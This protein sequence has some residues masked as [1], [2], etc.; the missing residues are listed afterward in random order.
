MFLDIIKKLDLP[1]IEIDKNQANEIL[2]KFKKFYS[3]SN[4]NLILFAFSL[5]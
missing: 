4:D 2:W 5:L 3:P 1:N